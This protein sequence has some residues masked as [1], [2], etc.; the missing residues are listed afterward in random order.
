MNRVDRK[1][2]FPLA[3][4]LS[5]WLVSTPALAAPPEIAT[6][7][8]AQQPFG[9]GQ[10]R[11]LFL[12]A[13]TASLWTDAASWSLD[14]P[15][16]MAIHYGMGFDT[17]DLVERTIKEMR[18]VDP[19]LSDAEL[20]K[21]TAQLNKVYPPVKAGDRLTALYLPGKPLAFFYN[22]APTSSIDGAY[23]KD[24]F[25]IWLSPDTSD[26]SLRKKLLKL[27]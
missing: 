16:A 14:A 8:H 21:L 3:F 15:T 6:I 26:P 12:N 20:T 4:C 17:D 5:T 10:V 23:A 9:E 24:F 19:N 13:Y 11:F 1:L 2:A 27:P 22:G 25:G 18:H 7:I